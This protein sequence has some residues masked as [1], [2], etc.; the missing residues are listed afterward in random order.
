MEVT[1]EGRFL[2]FKKDEGNILKYDFSDRSFIKTTNYRNPRIVASPQAFFRGWSFTQVFEGC[3]DEKYKLFIDKVRK[4]EHRCNN[5]GTFLQ[6]LYKYSVIE[7]WILQGFNVSWTCKLDIKSVPKDILRIFKEIN[8]EESFRLLTG[9]LDHKEVQDSVRYIF[10]EQGGDAVIKFLRMA[11]LY[12]FRTLI[13]DYN[14]EYKALIKYVQ[15]LKD[16]EG[17]DPWNTFSQIRDY[18]R[19]QKSMTNKYNKYPK[20]FATVHD[21]VTMNYNVFRKEY[22]KELFEN[23]IDLSL[24]HTGKQYCMVHPK[25][26]DDIKDEGVGLHHCVASYI[27]RVAEGKTRIL[28]LRSV[29]KPEKS[30]ITVEI[31]NKKVVQASG[32]YNRRLKNEEMDYL[33]HYCKLK[34]IKI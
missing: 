19:M 30:L 28:F 12:E 2:V 11:G 22:S 32:E 5:I 24:E 4:A 25:E 31:N 27:D 10:K 6:R 17:F 21:I 29:K 9:Q 33:R 23:Q 8:T 7:P 34:G 26:P 15:Y 3:V 16:R 18:A 13:R 20:Y 1:K 14:Y